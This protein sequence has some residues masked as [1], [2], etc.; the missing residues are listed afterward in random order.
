[1]KQA[2]LDKHKKKVHNVKL[3]IQFKEEIRE[4]DPLIS[5]SSLDMGYFNKESYKTGV[6]IAD[7][8]IDRN[9]LKKPKAKKKVYV[10]E[11]IE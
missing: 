2:F 9:L 6:L 10:S 3:E 7:K 8:Q 4:C 5:D 11:E 1:M